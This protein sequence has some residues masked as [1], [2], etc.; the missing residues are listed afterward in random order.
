MEGKRW[1]RLTSLRTGSSPGEKQAA[2]LGQDFSGLFQWKARRCWGV[3]YMWIRTRIQAEL[4][5]YIDVS[6]WGRL[7]HKML[8]FFRCRREK[9]Q[10]EKILAR[11]ILK[12]KGR[13][14]IL[15]RKLLFPKAL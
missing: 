15:N 11:K 13:P 8:W 14:E 9:V 1:P 5:L 4:A 10:G 2:H 7:D 6:L 3:R 12:T